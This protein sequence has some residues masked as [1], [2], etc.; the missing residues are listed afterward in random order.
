MD[1]VVIESTQGKSDAFVA[2]FA[3]RW[4]DWEARVR[5]YNE[6]HFGVPRRE[7]M[8]ALL[9]Q[10]TPGAPVEPTLADLLADYAAR[11]QT[12]LTGVPLVPGVAALLRAGRYSFFICSAAPEAEIRHI[13]A[14]HDLL[15]C[16]TAIFDGTTPKHEALR[17]IARDHPGRCLFVGDAPADQRAAREAGVPFVLR[18]T[19]MQPLLP[20][21]DAMIDDFH[22]FEAIVSALLP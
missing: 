19:G 9:G 3:N 12:A 18:R 15:A 2:V 8:R 22:G 6:A 7:K 21:A 10:I 14:H 17:R 13:L 4:P 11:L 20:D 5:R 1:G 16:V